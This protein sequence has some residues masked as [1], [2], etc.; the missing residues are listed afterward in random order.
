M[1]SR[2][3][4]EGCIATSTCIVSCQYQPE[5]MSIVCLVCCG[6]KSVVRWKT[7]AQTNRYPVND[8]GRRR[9]SQFRM[10]R[11]ETSHANSSGMGI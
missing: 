1:H 5:L 11:A 7:Y 3:Y 8:E 4:G 2:A 6:K 10:G 9:A